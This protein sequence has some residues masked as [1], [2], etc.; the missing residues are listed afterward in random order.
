MNSAKTP[1]G[2][3]SKGAVGIENYRDRIRLNLPRQ[4]FN[5]QQKRVSLGLPWTKENELTLPRQATL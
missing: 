5:G 1:T 2:K 3:A 4:W